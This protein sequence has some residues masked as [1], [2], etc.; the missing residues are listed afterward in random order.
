MRINKTEWL[1]MEPVDRFMEIYREA[2][3]QMIAREKNA[4]K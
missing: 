1:S 3:R 2:K 4:E